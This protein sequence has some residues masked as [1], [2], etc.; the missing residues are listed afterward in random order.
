[1]F[2]FVIIKIV[3]RIIAIAQ[4]LNAKKIKQN[5]NIF[6]GLSFAFSNLISSIND[7]EP[8]VAQKAISLFET[9]SESSIKSIIYC[10]ELQFD[11]VIP[12]RPHI[13]KILLILYTSASSHQSILNWEF[14][15]QRFTSLFIETQLKD[16]VLTVTDIS[17]ST[18]NA[19]NSKSLQRK[20]LISKFA[21]KKSGVVKQISHELSGFSKASLQKSN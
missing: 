12:D 16:E 15:M 10:F 1:M 17:G 11:C 3:S 7:I 8:M 18:S 2:L 5:Y 4:H 20:I 14:F 19:A 13:I 9:L 21:L 6:S